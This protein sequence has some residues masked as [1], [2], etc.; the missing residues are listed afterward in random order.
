MLRSNVQS[1]YGLQWQRKRW[2]MYVRHR[3]VSV[4]HIACRI[5][6]ESLF[7]RRFD[8]GMERLCGLFDA[9][10]KKINNTLITFQEYWTKEKH[11]RTW[12]GRLSSQ[13]PNWKI[14]SLKAKFPTEIMKWLKI[15]QTFSLG[16]CAKFF[17]SFSYLQLTF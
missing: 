16:I 11:E 2:R 12:N 7:S 10:E 17:I 5:R 13:R 1:L 3:V 15:W 14:F 6:N 9:R 8:V 4:A